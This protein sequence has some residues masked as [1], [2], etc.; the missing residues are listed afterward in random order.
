MWH[1]SKCK[2]SE[3]D[4]KKM[5]RWL[6]KLSEFERIETEP[7]KLNTLES[8]QIQSHQAEWVEHVV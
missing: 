2:K 6:S 1:N 3:F 8:S 5:P 4:L 7:A